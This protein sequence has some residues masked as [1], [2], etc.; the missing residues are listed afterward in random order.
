MA[1]DL[2]GML[3]EQLVFPM[4]SVLLWLVLALV[5][6]VVFWLISKAVKRIVVQILQS[7]GV[8]AWIE[9]HKIGSAIGNKKVSEVL[10]SLAKWYFIVFGLAIVV[11]TPAF[12][13]KFLGFDIIPMPGLSDFLWTLAKYLPM[14]LGGVLFFVLALLFAKYIGNQVLSIQHKLKHLAAAIL[15]GLIV[16]F[17]AVVALQMIL[18]NAIAQT[19]LQLLQIFIQPFI[20]ALAIVFGIV[21]GLAAGLGFKDELQKFAKEVKKEYWP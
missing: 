14:A 7:F 11:E 9:E 19:I 15:E 4:A 20:I 10:G 18:G 21:A 13:G 1:S 6:M 16:L 5:I 2:I 8:D 12:F 3:R 17:A